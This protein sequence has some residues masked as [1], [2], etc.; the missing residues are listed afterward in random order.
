MLATITPKTG[1]PSDQNLAW[2]SAEWSS[3]SPARPVASPQS[4]PNFWEG[5]RSNADA[6]RPVLRDAG[7]SAGSVRTIR[8]GCCG[9]WESAAFWTPGRNEKGVLHLTCPACTRGVATYNLSRNETA[10]RGQRRRLPIRQP[11]AVALLL[12][13]T[14]VGMSG[15][16]S[17]AAGDLRQGITRRYEQAAGWSLLAAAQ[18]D[19]AQGAQRRSD[20]GFSPPP[21]QYLLAGNRRDEVLE[22]ARVIGSES[23]WE[24]SAGLHAVVYVPEL[25]MTRV[26]VDAQAGPWRDYLRSRG[27]DVG[28]N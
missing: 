4:G 24:E 12:C 27:E 10:S 14:L 9:L 22:H 2:L 13:A 19:G 25:G 18:A 3:S 11:L 21:E 20:Y 5:M 28:A 7:I 6:I 26:M 17:A 1:S 15:K 8:C 16:L 23:G